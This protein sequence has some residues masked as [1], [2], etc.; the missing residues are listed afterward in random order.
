MALIDAHHHLWRYD[1][2][3]YPWIPA[4]SRLAFTYQGD[5]LE[6]AAASAGVTGTVAVQARQC[7]AET[8]ALCDLAAS[9]PLIRGVVGWLPL[10]DESI[11]RLLEQWAETSALKGLRHVLQEEPAEFFREARF[12]RGLAAMVPHGLPYDL[13]IYEHQIPLG[14]ELLDAHP[15]LP[16]I[17]DHIAKPVIHNGEVSAT[18]RDGM[19]QMA[20][21][22]N[23]IGVKIS[24]MVTEVRD[25][26]LDDATLCRYIDET[27]EIFGYERVLFGTD[28]PV[29]LLRVEEYRHWPDLVRSHLAS[30]SASEQAA[31]FSGNAERCYKL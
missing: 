12:H 9:C 1:A 22:D 3:E 13:L 28:W 30:L 29:C 19:R 27:I 2:A 23:L 4:E 16:M 25:A 26:N 17:L 15:Q 31:I 5:E 11:P 21:R 24:G 7:I 14:I 20:T 18:W 8:A 10:I 6:S